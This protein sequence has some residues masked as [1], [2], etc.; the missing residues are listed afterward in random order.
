MIKLDAEENG[1]KLGHN[2]PGGMEN[3]SAIMEKSWQFPIKLN[4][5]FPYDLTITLLS[6]YPREMKT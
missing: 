1:E 5:Q 2:F 3:D 4:I 6:I